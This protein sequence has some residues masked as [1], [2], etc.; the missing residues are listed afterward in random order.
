MD[1]NNCERCHEGMISHRVISDTLD[2]SVCDACSAIAY[3]VAQYPQ[4]PGS[5]TIK[6][7]PQE[8]QQLQ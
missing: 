7:I 1:D 5:I 8:G 2:I 3:D 4:Q 6:P